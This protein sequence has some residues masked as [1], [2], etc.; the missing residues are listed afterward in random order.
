MNKRWIPIA[1]GVLWAACAKGPYEPS[2]VHRKLTPYRAAPPASLRYVARY[3]ASL[4]PAARQGE[5]VPVRPVLGLPA[6]LRPGAR[7]VVSYLRRDQG[8]LVVPR[9]LALAPPGQ[10]C[11]GPACR[12]LLP[13]RRLGPTPLGH[14]VSLLRLR[15]RVPADT[16]PGLYDLHHRLGNTW[17]RSPSAVDVHP[18]VDPAAPFTFVHLSDTHQGAE[19]DPRLRSTLAW[20]NRLRPRPAFAVLTGDL[21]EYGPNRAH[22]RRARQA[23]LRLRLPVFVIPGNHDYYRPGLGGARAPR[24]GYVEERGL[25]HFLAT[26]HPFLAFRFSYAGVRFLA[27]DTGPGATLR[28][29][30]RWQLITTEGL[31]APQLRDIRRFLG[32]R[33]AG[34]SSVRAQ[35]LLGHAP[36]RARMTRAR[37]GCAPGRHGAFQLGRAKLERLLVGSWRRWHRPLLY[38]HGH[39]HWNDLYARADDPRCG[40]F[41]AVNAPQP[42]MGTRPCWWVLPTARSP[43]LVGTQSATKHNALRSGGLLQAGLRYG[44]GA[45]ASRGFRLIRVHG[46][47]WDSALYRLYHRTAVRHRD[48]PEGYLAPGSERTATLPPCPSPR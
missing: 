39:L 25:R 17:R 13:P 20:I 24:D 4:Y 33:R 26:F 21:V 30:K 9:A 23:L 27:V 1:L 42:R 35:V 6:L 5:L 15:T 18:A 31:G 36:P 41:R 40:G 12:R 11:P 47:R 29:Y 22:W 32:R 38:L 28:T 44:E 19:P 2:P 10:P 16:P 46:R 34:H 8:R 43:L 48:H 14:G 45:G 3:F 37:N 7:L